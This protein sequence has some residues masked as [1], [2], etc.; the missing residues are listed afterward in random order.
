MPLVFEPEGARHLTVI[1]DTLRRFTAQSA[2]AEQLWEPVKDFWVENG[3]LLSLDQANLGIMETDWAENRAKIPQD[4]LRQTLGKG[5]T[6]LTRI[7]L[8]S[9]IDDFTCGFKGFRHSIKDSSWPCSR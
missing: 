6:M 9:R 8:S 7:L 3:F 2:G 1:H 5:F 4:F